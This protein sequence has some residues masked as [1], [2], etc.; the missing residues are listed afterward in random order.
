MS[1]FYWAPQRWGYNVVRLHPDAGATSVTVTFRGVTQGGASSGWRWG[2]VATDNALTTS[3]YSAVQQGSDGQLSFCV[4][5]NESL[6]MVVVGAPTAMQKIIWDQ[7]YPSIYR[8]PYMVQLGGAWPEGFR[9]GQPDA[10]PSGT[11]RHSNGGGCAPANLPASVY[12]GPYAQVLGGMVSGNA[13]IEDQAVIQSGA[14][15]SGGTVGALSVL[16]RFNVSGSA[17]VQTSFYPP[18]FFE[19]G[20]GLSGS[21]RLFGDV[22]YRGQGLNRTSGAFYGFVDAN[23]TATATI[24]DVTV[25]PPYAWR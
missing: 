14:R 19:T 6:W 1:P 11:Q 5:P 3:R 17:V 22:E 24:N 20:Q 16:Y 13:R 10:C 7:P 8:F 15:V 18:G 4:N 9:N 21:A 25:A 12:V 23:T 2:L